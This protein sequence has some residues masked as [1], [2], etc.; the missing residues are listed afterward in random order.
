MYHVPLAVQYIYMDGGMKEVE[1]GMGMRGVRFQEEG[2][3]W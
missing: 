3:E 2:R 1:I